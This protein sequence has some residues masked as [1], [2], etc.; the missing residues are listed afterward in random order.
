MHPDVRRSQGMV[1]TTYSFSDSK[2][3]GSGFCT[4]RCPYSRRPMGLEWIERPRRTVLGPP[5]RR[6]PAHAA[7]SQKFRYADVARRKE[8]CAFCNENALMLLENKA[9]RFL[10]LQSSPLLQVPKEGCSPLGAATCVRG[11]GGQ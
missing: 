1:E 2:L 8:N 7:R 4:Q 11:F 3:T 10:Y 9:N 5:N 6:Y